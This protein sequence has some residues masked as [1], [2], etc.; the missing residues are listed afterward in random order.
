M[1]DMK[2]NENAFNVHELFLDDEWQIE[3]KFDHIY[4]IKVKGETIPWL[5]KEFKDEKYAKLEYKALM[6]YQD[7]SV[8]RVL[9]YS[10]SKRFS[11]IILSLEAG[12][13]LYEYTDKFGNLSEDELKIIARQLLYILKG[14]HDKK[15]F[16]KDIKPENII[17]DPES[18]KVCLIDFE[19]KIT[20]NYCSPEQLL[21][22]N[23]TYKTDIW[24]LGVTLYVL[25]VGELPFSSADEILKKDPWY[26]RF[27]SD[28]CKNFLNNLLEKD[29]ELR[30]DS[31][32]ALEDTFLENDI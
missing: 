15:K 23:V 20:K 11:Y 1:T 18:K 5:I 4:S 19:Q 27:L 6:D 24:S 30:Y 14:I 28:E 3:K 9:S 12:M 7:L 25:L 21:G 31:D 17:Y 8:P 26:P 16:H 29:Y 22:K 13:D 32:Y 2:I 10:F